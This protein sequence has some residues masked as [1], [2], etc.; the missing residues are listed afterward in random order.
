[1]TC[2]V[3]RVRDDQ[4]MANDLVSYSGDVGQLTSSTIKNSLAIILKEVVHV[5]NSVT[6]IL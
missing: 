5:K 1:M 3:S 2:R 6:V 4:H